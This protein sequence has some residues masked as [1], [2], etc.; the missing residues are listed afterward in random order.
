MSKKVDSIL[1]L[2]NKKSTVKSSSVKKQATRASFTIKP[3]SPLTKKI[4]IA[5]FKSEKV[6]SKKQ[7]RGISLD[8]RKLEISQKLETSDFTGKTNFSKSFK[9]SVYNDSKQSDSIGSILKKKHSHPNFL[10]FQNSTL[11]YFYKKRKSNSKFTSLKAKLKSSL[12]PSI[13]QAGD[14]DSNFIELKKKKSQSKRM[15]YY[16]HSPIKLRKMKR[17]CKGQQFS[18]KAKKSIIGKIENHINPHSIIHKHEQN[19]RKQSPTKSFRISCGRDQAMS[20]AKSKNGATVRSV[21][22]SGKTLKFET[23][24]NQKKKFLKM[25]KSRTEKKF[26]KGV[27]MG[28]ELL[29]LQNVKK[30]EKLPKNTKGLEFVKILGRGVFATVYQAEDTILKETV[31]VK[32]YKKGKFNIFW[33]REIE[34][35]ER[36][37]DVI[38]DRNHKF[39]RFLCPMLRTVNTDNYVKNQ[40]KNFQ[41]NFFNLKK[42]IPI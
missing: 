34:V 37:N 4:K 32:T 25:K 41:N 16:P 6:S 26:L 3:S 42:K 29:K 12:R 17:K 5:P 7:P 1:N 8:Q 27:E 22:K 24:K 40:Q 35:L 20:P 13:P 10:R 28:G 14:S 18:L 38:D 33:K 15:N 9:N 39:V 21:G 19:S 2:S 36:I 11:N 31:A 23:K 30:D